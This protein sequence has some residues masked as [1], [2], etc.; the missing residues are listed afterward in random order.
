VTAFGLNLP[1]SVPEF[2]KIFCKSKFLDP[3]RQKFPLR[4][5]LNIADYS[6]HSIGRTMAEALG[7]KSVEYGAPRLHLFT[8]VIFAKNVG[9]KSNR[10]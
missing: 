6:L 3:E 9:K 1:V 7:R 4:R 5:S 8:K 2:V 10:C